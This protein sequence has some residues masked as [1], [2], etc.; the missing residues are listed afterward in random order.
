MLESVFLVRAEI[1]SSYVE[2][3]GREFALQPG[4]LLTADVIVD[5]RNLLEFLFDP[6]FAAGR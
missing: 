2:A 4:M 1:D 5:R 3:Y 6:I